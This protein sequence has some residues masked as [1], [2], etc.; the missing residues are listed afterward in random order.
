MTVDVTRTM[1]AKDRR[2]WRKR[3]NARAGHSIRCANL[4]GKSCNC[5]A[6]ELRE[7]GNRERAEKVTAQANPA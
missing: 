7:W 5:K 6:K 3:M 2:I 1:N 4:R